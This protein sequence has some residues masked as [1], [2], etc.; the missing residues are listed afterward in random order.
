MR[1]STFIVDLMGISSGPRQVSCEA[2]C[3]DIGLEYQAV[4]EFAPVQKTPLASKAKNDARQGTI[5]E[6]ELK[7]C[8]S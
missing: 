3:T 1:S 4:V 7:L 2:S 6:G 8:A 5:D